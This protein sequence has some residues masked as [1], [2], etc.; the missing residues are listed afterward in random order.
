MEYLTMWV[1][2]AMYFYNYEQKDRLLYAE[3]LLKDWAFWTN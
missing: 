2:M 3:Q 1:I